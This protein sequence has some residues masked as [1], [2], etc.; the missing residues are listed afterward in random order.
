M[1]LSDKV[2]FISGAGSGMGRRA[3]QIFAQEGAQIVAN[4]YNA[5]ALNETVALVEAD[6][7][8]IV[9]IAGDVSKD[10]DVQR[11]MAE[12]AKRFGKI[13]VLYNNAGVALDSDSSVTTMSEEIWARTLSINTTGIG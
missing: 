7:G 9:G 12:G 1:R 4:D 5:A 10:A 13:N 8:E 2:V 11:V 3:S 6:G